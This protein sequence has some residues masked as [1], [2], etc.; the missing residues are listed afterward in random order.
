MTRLRF[1]G[2][3]AL[4]WAALLTA[5]APLFHCLHLATHDR[6]PASRRAPPAPPAHRARCRGHGVCA[7][8]GRILD[9]GG[10]GDKGRREHAP[11]TCSLCQAFASLSAV[12][13]SSRAPPSVFAP[14]PHCA[15][16][17]SERLILEEASRSS[18]FP[19]GPPAGRSSRC[20]RFTVSVSC[21]TSALGAESP[22][23]FG[24]RKS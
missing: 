22:L 20:L 3:E 11:A 16:L 12:V 7:R 14:A 2:L 10:A 19:R 21:A 15:V 17:P 9:A 24:V 13:W 1:E 4:F 18:G 23:R 5:L 8:A 6:Q